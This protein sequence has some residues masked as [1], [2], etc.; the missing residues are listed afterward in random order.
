MS[1]TRE[2]IRGSF[3]IYAGVVLLIIIGLATNVFLARKLGK[4]NWGIFSILL[5][6]VSF[7]TA[8]ADLGLNYVI[9]YT[10]SSLSHKDTSVIKKALSA[11]LK[12]KIILIFLIGFGI[13]IFANSLASLFKI[14]DGANYFVAS[15]VFF[16]LVNLTSTFSTIVLG[17][18][19]FRENT[20]VSILDNVLEL[21][22]AYILVILG[23]GVNGAI[24]GYITGVAVGTIVLTILIRQYISLAGSKEE[25]IIN[26]FKFGMYSG[27][28]GLAATTSLWMGSIIIGLFV[29]SIEVGIYNIALSISTSI[30]GLVS[31][32]N[33]VLF[34]FFASAEGKGEES[35]GY[36]NTAIKYGSFIA[37]PAMI[38][39]ALSAGAVVTIFF[40]QQY[41]ES[42]VPLLLLSY[43]CFDQMF[44][45]M[46]VSYLGA[47]KQTKIVGYSAAASTIA[48]VLLSL[49]L[50]PLLGIIGAAIAIVLTRLANAVIMVIWSNRSIGSKYDLG[51]MTIP[52][53]GSLLMGAFL[54][55]VVEYFVNPA[56]SLI[57]LLIF[58][59]AG[60]I[61]YAIFEQLLGFDVI[62]LTRKIVSSLT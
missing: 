15:A 28:V 7:L 55:F 3:W 42:A 20:I 43:I 50:I 60:I 17:L 9:S 59:G 52:I 14:T 23:F 8:L 10:A 34:P 26:V 35:I 56:G 48:N 16:V 51:A 38:G 2:I 30:G 32:V 41:V 45:G 40:G 5:V 62:A 27:L 31:G 58:M 37:F 21:I 44:S 39:L 57:S 47:K 1:K 25:N 61:S 36:L 13:F 29:G 49:L 54:L 24:I 4:D 12:Y 33:N 22:V 46:I 6:S 11:P 53:I 19:K 18:K